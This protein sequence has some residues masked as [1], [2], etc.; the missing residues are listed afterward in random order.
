M[1]PYGLWLRS[2]GTDADIVSLPRRRCSLPC[3]RLLGWAALWIS[4]ARRKTALFL[5]NPASF[6]RNGGSVGLANMAPDH[7]LWVTFAKAMV[8]F[9]AP[10]AEA[11]GRRGEP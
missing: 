9:V 8:P 11:V 6:V 7:P 3:R 2:E 5:D 10:T 4:L 1:R